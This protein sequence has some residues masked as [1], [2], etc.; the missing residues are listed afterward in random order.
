M[1][2]PDTTAVAV[3]LAP[4]EGAADGVVLE[5]LRAALAASPGA[6]PLAIGSRI[7][8][9]LP[10]HTPDGSGLISMTP[11]PFAALILG[12]GVIAEVA[13]AVETLIARAAAPIDQ[14][15]SVVVAGGEHAIT[16]GL[17][18]IWVAMLTHRLPGLSR[19]AYA[20][21]WRI[22]HAPFGARLK[23]A[24]GYRQL[25]ADAHPE[26]L[27]ALASRFAINRYDG[28]GQ[29]YFDTLGAMAATRASPEVLRDGTADEMQFIDHARSML[30]MF[31]F[32]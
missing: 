15:S 3:L 28:L 18:A 16:P 27:G 6:Q 7:R 23:S 2:K 13:V 8:R 29:V 32:A 11:C 12:R 14:P 20:R 30:M 1:P 31:S 26:E 19:D 22:G 25:H 5:R 10:K 21:R 9:D 17:G 24:A 4:A